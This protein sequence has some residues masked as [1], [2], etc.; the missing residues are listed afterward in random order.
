MDRRANNPGFILGY[1]GCDKSLGERVLAGE[2]GLEPS[3]NSYDW[4]GHGI[5]FWEDDWRRADEWSKDRMSIPDSKIQEPFVVGAIIDLGVNLS[6]MRR[7][8]IELVKKG[9]HS[10]RQLQK[11]KGEAMPVNSGGQDRFKREL[12]CAVI[13]LVHVFR[14][15][16]KLAEFETVRGMFFEGE[17]AYAGS[18]FRNKNHVQVCVRNPNRIHG[19]F[20]VLET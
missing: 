16:E 1:H 3:N 7:E 2:Q 10:L 11:M 6:L 12:D 15:A 5:Y 18:G 4:L 14:R 13:H 9:Y 17:E 19:Y 20:R 8:D